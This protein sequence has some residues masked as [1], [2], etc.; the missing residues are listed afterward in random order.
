MVILDLDLN[1][2]AVK[3]IMTVLSYVYNNRVAIGIIALLFTLAFLGLVV[4][5]QLIS[6][7]E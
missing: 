6:N 1:F 5:E 2:K 4:L 7:I 3:K